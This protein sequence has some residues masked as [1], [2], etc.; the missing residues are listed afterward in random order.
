LKGG[1]DREARSSVL[2]ATRTGALKQEIEAGHLLNAVL[3]L[4]LLF[5]A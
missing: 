5:D 3:A 2:A 4:E 1:R